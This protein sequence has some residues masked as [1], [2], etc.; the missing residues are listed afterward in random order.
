MQ[1]V[2]QFTNFPHYTGSTSERPSH[3][4]SDTELLDRSTITITSTI[5]STSTITPFSFSKKFDD[6]AKNKNIFASKFSAFIP[7]FF[8]KFSVSFSRTRICLDFI[9]IKK[10]IRLR[11][12]NWLVMKEVL[13]EIFFSTF[14]FSLFCPKTSLT[15]L[16]PIYECESFRWNEPGIGLKSPGLK[17]RLAI[18]KVIWASSQD[19]QKQ[20]KVWL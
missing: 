6:S 16:W 20:P 8:Q 5:T 7:I 12:K 11:E 1:Q 18:N 19:Y 14:Y 4:F 10:L 15:H 17:V 13:H 2:S 3:S 9:K